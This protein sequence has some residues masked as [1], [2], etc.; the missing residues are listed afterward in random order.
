MSVDRK[1]HDVDVDP[2]MPLLYALR[3]DESLTWSEIDDSV[4]KL[5]AEVPAD[6]VEEFILV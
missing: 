3:N 2:D 6:H 4:A 5:D 1:D